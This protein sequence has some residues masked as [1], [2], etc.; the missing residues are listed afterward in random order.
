MRAQFPRPSFRAV[1]LASFAVGLL[2]CEPDPPAPPASLIP[3]EL[4][5]EEVG[6]FETEC[7]R[8][9]SFR[10]YQLA[11]FLADQAK[12]G[13][14]DAVRALELAGIACERDF[15]PAC[16]QNAEFYRAGIG[17]FPDPREALRLYDRACR[18]LHLFA[19]Y[20]QALL[21]RKV[22]VVAPESGEAV[23]L[24]ERTCHHQTLNN[25]QDIA[26]EVH[27][28]EK[29]ISRRTSEYQVCTR[30]WN[31]ACHMLGEMYAAGE[32]VERDLERSRLMFERACSQ[33]DA[34]SCERVE[35]LDAASARAADRASE[36][37]SR[38]A[39]Q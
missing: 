13:P 31:A 21:L 32:E 7:Q 33:G 9:D 39:K 28:S 37:D 36:D 6:R 3:G 27:E 38:P 4:S 30:G 1:A 20:R 19:C 35:K 16:F 12:P 26:R 22:P 17:V 11:G 10:C 24:L 29:R 8:G 5:A 18:R 23:A 34:A 15:L 14:N 25:C 2:A